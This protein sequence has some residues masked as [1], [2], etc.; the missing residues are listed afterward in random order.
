MIDS[1]TRAN[2]GSLVSRHTN[3][4]KASAMV[5]NIVSGL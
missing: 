4:I 2:D 1:I 5:S 3:C